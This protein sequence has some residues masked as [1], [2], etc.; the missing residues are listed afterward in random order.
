MGELWPEQPSCLRTTGS[1]SVRWS[2]PPGPLKTQFLSYN[3]D[4]SLLISLPRLPGCS[5]VPWARDVR[6]QGCSDLSLSPASLPLGME[7]FCAKVLSLLILAH[8]DILYVQA[9]DEP[10]L[11]PAGWMSPG[12]PLNTAGYFLSQATRAVSI[13]ARAFLRPNKNWP[14]RE[15]RQYVGGACDPQ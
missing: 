6:S 5:L 10:R 1:L 3:L 9:P 2:G 15:I 11:R 13:G 8:S 7:E 14:E 4:L 12:K